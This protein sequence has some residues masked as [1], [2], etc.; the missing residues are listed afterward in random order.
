MTVKSEKR[1]LRCFV[2]MGRTLGNGAINRRQLTRSNNELKA[3]GNQSGG[4]K[5]KMKHLKRVIKHVK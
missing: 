4:S 3:P 5:T 2:F 1:K